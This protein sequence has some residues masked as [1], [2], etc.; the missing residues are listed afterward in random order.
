MVGRPARDRVEELELTGLIEVLDLPHTFY[1][2]LDHLGAD[3]VKT[4]DSQAN[5]GALMYRVG[6]IDEAEDSQWSRP[7]RRAAASS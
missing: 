3:H 7:A 6:L 4:A 5:L 2:G 1:D